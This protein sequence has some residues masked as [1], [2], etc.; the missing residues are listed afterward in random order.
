MALVIAFVPNR[1]KAIEELKRVVKPGG[2]IASYMWDLPGRAFTQ[3]PL[4]DAIGVELTKRVPQSFVA[5]KF[6]KGF[7]RSYHLRRAS[8][9]GEGNECQSNSDV[10][11]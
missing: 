5:T 6:A 1:S 9:R 2:T 7:R 3:Q 10:R 4:L 8:E 11:R